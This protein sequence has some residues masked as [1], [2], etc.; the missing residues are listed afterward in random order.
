ME[1]LRSIDLKVAD[2][3]RKDPEFLREWFR[4]ELETSV[5]DQMRAL[6]EL[7][8][9]T[10]AALA[11]A[12]GY[13]GEKPMKQSAISRFERSTDAKWELPAVLRMAEAMGGIVRVLIIPAEHAIETIEAEEKHLAMKEI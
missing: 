4:A 9:M 11:E 13:D 7:R 1:T 2:R 10:Q 3:L 12:T 8:D 5:P 6:R